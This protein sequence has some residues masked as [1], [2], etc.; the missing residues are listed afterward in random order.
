MR[1][2]K[3]GFFFLIVQQESFHTQVS[4]HKQSDPSLSAWVEKDGE[5]FLPSERKKKAFVR[6]V[7]EASEGNA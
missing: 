3:K 1:K 7:H 5:T 4:P 2:S 6:N